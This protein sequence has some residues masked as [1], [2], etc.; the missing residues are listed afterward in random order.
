[1]DQLQGFVAVEALD[2]GGISREMM[3][4]GKCIRLWLGWKVIQTL[5][6]V[7]VIQFFLK[8]KVARSYTVVTVDDDNGTYV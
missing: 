2:D 4:G 6:P 1:L 7:M 5:L 8:K 3:V